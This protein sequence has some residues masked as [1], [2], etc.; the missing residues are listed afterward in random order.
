V[1]ATV[2][3]QAHT[4]QI[5]IG[6][7]STG[8]AGATFLTKKYKG[9]PNGGPRG[10]EPVSVLINGEPWEVRIG[11]THDEFSEILK[12][13]SILGGDI[14]WKSQ[15]GTAYGPLRINTVGP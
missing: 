10:G 3:R 5:E 14:F 2:D 4:R 12:D 11:M 15:R 13:N 6:G 9:N 1:Q 8:V 7:A